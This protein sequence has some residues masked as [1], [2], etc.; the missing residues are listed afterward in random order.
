MAG[1]E[2]RD[3]EEGGDGW[4]GHGWMWIDFVY[5]IAAATTEDVAVR[6]RVISLTR[7]ADSR[8]RYSLVKRIRV[9]RQN[10]DLSSRHVTSRVEDDARSPPPTSISFFD[11]IN[12]SNGTPTHIFCMK[13]REWPNPSL[14]TTYLLFS[15]S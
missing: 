14:R 13:W 6:R 9:S 3:G 5:C 4:L 2:G 7:K 15:D 8:E 10:H 11:G 12:S 1:R